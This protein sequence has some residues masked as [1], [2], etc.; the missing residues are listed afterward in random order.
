MY[1]EALKRPFHFFSSSFQTIFWLKCWP[2]FCMSY[3]PELIHNAYIEIIPNENRQFPG[4][5]FIIWIYPGQTYQPPICRKSNN[6]RVANTMK[7]SSIIWLVFDRI[8]YF[9]SLFKCFFSRTEP[10]SVCPWPARLQPQ[11][12]C[13]GC[14][15]RSTLC[16]VRENILRRPSSKEEKAGE[17]SKILYKTIL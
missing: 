3:N 11:R 8:V 6:E 2:P 1:K 14:Q 5:K 4:F 10:Y 15:Q 9:L 12:S 17:A 7:K 13:P 16:R